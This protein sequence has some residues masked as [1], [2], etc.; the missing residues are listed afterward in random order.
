MMLAFLDPKSRTVYTFSI[1]GMTMALLASQTNSFLLLL[2]E[3]DYVFTTTNL[4]PLNEEILKGLPVLFFTFF[5]AERRDDIT[6]VAYAV[7]VGFAIMENVTIF[8]QATD[9]LSLAWAL[10]RCIGAGLMHG[11]CTAS[12]GIGMYF[13]KYRHKLFFP[14]TVSLLSI[15]V[16]YHSIFNSLV[17]TENYKY[18]GILLPILTYIPLLFFSRK[19]KKKATF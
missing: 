8:L 19:F 4:T 9:D 18:F 6:P 12:V 16:L 7:G 10:S 1:V 2:A 3:S 14:G 13:I 17:Q 5:M 15:A 11:I